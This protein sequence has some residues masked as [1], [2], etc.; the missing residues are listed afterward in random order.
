LRKLGPHVDFKVLVVILDFRT[1]YDRRDDGI[2]L[3]ENVIVD[4]EVGLES[5]HL[6]I[7]EERIHQD[8]IQPVLLHVAGVLADA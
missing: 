3:Q 6:R 1:L 2:I 7:G 5:R 4:V 8:Q